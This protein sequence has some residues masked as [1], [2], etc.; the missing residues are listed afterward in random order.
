MK[1]F[2]EKKIIGGSATKSWK[3]SRS[4]RYGSIFRVD[5][6]ITEGGGGGW[7]SPPTPVLIRLTMV[8]IYCTVYMVFTYF[9]Q[10]KRKADI[11]IK[12]D[13]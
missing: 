4:L 9:E 13:N 5:S 10:S 12:L 6:K 2:E 7:I 11:I 1:F 3:G 8:Y